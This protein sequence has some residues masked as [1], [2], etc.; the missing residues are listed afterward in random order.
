MSDNKI[1]EEVEKYFDKCAPLYSKIHIDMPSID[2]WQ[3]GNL[4]NEMDLTKTPTVLDLGTGDGNLL[5]HIGKWNRECKLI[6]ID[7][8]E[9]MIEVAR[10]NLLKEGL[11]ARFLKANMEKI[12]LETDSIDYVVSNGA[13]HHVKDKQ[14]LYSEI[15]RVL[16][17]GGKLIVIDGFDILDDEYRNL[18]KELKEKDPVFWVSYIDDNN[19]Y[20]EFLKKETPAD[21]IDHPVEYHL[22]PFQLKRLLED[23]GFVNVRI[24]ASPLNF[25]IYIGEKSV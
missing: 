10:D 13:L 25:A 17:K 18:Q 24:I 9:K 14:S 7:L 11:S 21:L 8:S 12:D 5:L 16:K 19:R 15:F 6:G 1:Y 20:Q 23:I 4:F 22:S 3:F 2:N